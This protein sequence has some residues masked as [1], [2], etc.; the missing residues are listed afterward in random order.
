MDIFYHLRMLPTYLRSAYINFHYLPYKQAIHFPIFTNKLKC[1]NGGK[2]IIDSPH[3]KPGMIKL[4][5]RMVGVYPD[6][7]ITW[8]NIGSTVIF[9]GRANIGSDS[10]LSFGTNSVVEFGDDFMCSASLKLVSAKGL[11]FGKSVRIGWD[12]IIMDTNFHPLYN[13]NTNKFEPASGAIEIGDF[14]WFATGCRV[15]HSVKTPERCI[16]GMNSIITKGSMMK[17][18]CVMAGNP[19]H[20]IKENVVRKLGEDKEPF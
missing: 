2:I 12:N 10:Y 6:N 17:S 19:V 7:G 20:I 9:H 8:E 1:I 11:K 14:N 15:M 16:F 13:M 5:Y 18:Y 4:G 3:I